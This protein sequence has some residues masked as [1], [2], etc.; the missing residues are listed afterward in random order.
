MS[1]FANAIFDADVF[2]IDGVA[3][4]VCAMNVLSRS[5]RPDPYGRQPWYSWAVQQFSVVERGYNARPIGKMTH[6]VPSMRRLK[7]RASSREV[8]GCRIAALGELTS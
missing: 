6:L 7:V 3:R 8:V 1:I 4:G 2:L 5:R